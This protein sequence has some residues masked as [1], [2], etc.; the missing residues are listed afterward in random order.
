MKGRPI[1]GGSSRARLVNS[2]FSFQSIKVIFFFKERK[3]LNF[4]QIWKQ[5]RIKRKIEAINME[6]V[7]RV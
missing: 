5:H 4:F 2:D 3:L 1:S 6:R 7:L